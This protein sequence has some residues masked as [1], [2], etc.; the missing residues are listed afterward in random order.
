[1]ISERLT[2]VVERELG[3]SGLK[4]EASTVAGEVPGWDSLRHLTIIA[5]VEK[6]FGVRFKSL[7]LL[8][9]RSIGDLQALV[10]RKLAT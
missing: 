3:L 9:L 8:R 6:E 2:R 7:E 4:L 10:D 1:M 5:A